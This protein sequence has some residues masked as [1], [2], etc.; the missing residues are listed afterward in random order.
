[1]GSQE[2]TGSY[3]A[4]LV[5]PVERTAWVRDLDL[6][7]APFPGLGIRVDAYEVLNVVTVEA[8]DPDGGV[9]C[10]VEFDGG[11]L[12]ADEA[13]KKCGS[14][15]FTEG[16][17]PGSPAAEAAGP[18]RISL[19]T[20]A[21]GRQWSKRY[22]LPFPPFAGLSLRAGRGRSLKIFTV[23]VGDRPGDEVECYAGF[24]GGDADA[25]TEE[26]CAALGFEEDY[27]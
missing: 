3:R 8:G 7:F 23:V 15:G 13:R 27:R 2:R 11:A 17:F 20:F 9:A 26:E 24:E 4:R 5:L 1:M 19:I 10:V 12:T 14:L 25:V 6:P 21:A 16:A 18:V 22:D